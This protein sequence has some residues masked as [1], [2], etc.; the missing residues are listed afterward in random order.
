MWK[1]FQRRWIMYWGGIEDRSDSDETTQT[2]MEHF[3][4][5]DEQT[6][7]T[8]YK[9]GR[10]RIV[11]TWIIKNPEKIP[12]LDD[13]GSL[14]FAT[15]CTNIKNVNGFAMIGNCKYLESNKNEKRDCTWC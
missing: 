9:R 10:P 2:E 13:R 6:I 14:T 4:Y 12:F 15:K 1:A 3:E 5:R 11:F 8:I 7:F